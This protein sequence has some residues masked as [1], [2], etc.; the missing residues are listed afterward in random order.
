VI[1][2]NKYPVQKPRDLIEFH[3]GCFEDSSF[4]LQ[5]L[6]YRCLVR[7]GAIEHGDEV[8]YAVTG[9]KPPSRYMRPESR[10][11][12]IPYITHEGCSQT[13]LLPE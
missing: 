9:Y 4:D 13:G 11:Y 10:G 8:I 7:Q 1:Y 2:S 12:G 5:Y 6:P 3:E